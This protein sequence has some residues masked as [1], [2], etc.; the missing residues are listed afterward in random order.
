MPT[1][2]TRVFVTI[3]HYFGTITKIAEIVPSSRYGMEKPL[4]RMEN[5]QHLDRKEFDVKN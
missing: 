3:P 1:I 4:Y 2:G 5:G